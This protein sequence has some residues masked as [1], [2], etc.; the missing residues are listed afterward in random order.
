MNRFLRS[1]LRILIA[2][3][4]L[5]NV[6]LAFHAY[7][8]THFYD[9]D[10]V[11]I[12]PQDKKNFLDHTKDLLFGFNFVKEKNPRPESI[13][14]TIN[15]TTKNGLRLEGW[16]KRIQDPKGTAILFHGHGGNKS[17]VLEEAYEFL[18]MRYNVFLLDFRAHG[19]S[20]GHTCT[21]GFNEAEDVKLA[22]DF[23]RNTGEKNVVLWGISLGAASITRCISVYNCKP[24]KVILELPFGS[25]QE[26]VKARFRMMG[27]PSQPF[28]LL[29]TFWGGVENGFWAFDNKP[30]EYVRKITCPVLLQFAKNDIRVTPKERED[31]FNNITAPKKMVLYEN[32]AHESLC[33]KENA[34]WVTTVS[35]FLNQ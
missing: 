15:L 19:N 11:E 24:D 22:Y 5:L 6:V 18:K 12:K 13:F 32:S 16:Y 26:A 27:L 28:A 8:F 14:Q 35:A 25:I 10:D 21:I 31:I 9:A 7:K 20:E 23:I 33:K 29:L 4:I 30:S 34:K 3:F 1:C 2:L 17:G